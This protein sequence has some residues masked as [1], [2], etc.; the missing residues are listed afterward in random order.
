M[1][2]HTHNFIETYQGLV[3]YGLDRETDENTVI[4]YLQK[5]S[6][7]TLMRHLASRMTPEELEEIFMMINRILK[8]H[9]SEDEYHRLFLKDDHH[10]G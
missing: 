3:G 6:D 1:E 10:H 2:Q 4:Y 5:F 9:L 7:D 8:H